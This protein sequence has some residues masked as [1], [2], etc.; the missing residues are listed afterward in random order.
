LYKLL[1]RYSKLTEEEA[2]LLFDQRKKA[3]LQSLQTSQKISPSQTQTQPIPKSTPKKQP[4]QDS[5]LKNPSQ[6]SKSPNQPRNQKTL[7]T[8]TSSK[9][10][11]DTHHKSIKNPLKNCTP[12]KSTSKST[13]PLES[14]NPTHSSLPSTTYTS[15]RSQT[16]LYHQHT[17]KKTHTSS[18]PSSSSPLT[19]LLN[20]KATTLSHKLNNKLSQNKA[21]PQQISQIQQMQNS[22][23]NLLQR[24]N[25]KLINTS[26]DG[27]K[28]IDKQNKELNNCIRKRNKSLSKGEFGKKGEIKPRSASLRESPLG[29]G[30]GKGKGRREF[31]RDRSEGSAGK[32]DEGKREARNWNKSEGSSFCAQEGE[33]EEQILKSIIALDNQIKNVKLGNKGKRKGVK[34]SEVVI[35]HFGEGGT[36]GVTVS[37]TAGSKKEPF[38]G[39]STISS[40]GPENKMNASASKKKNPARLEKKTL[41]KEESK[42]S[43]KPVMSSRTDFSLNSFRNEGYSIYNRMSIDNIKNLSACKSEITASEPKFNNSYCNQIDFTNN[44]TQAQVRCFNYSELQKLKVFPIYSNFCLGK[45]FRKEKYEL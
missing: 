31:K 32:D 20:T 43:K 27:I 38:A 34:D 44:S 30:K 1:L 28:Q 3:V 35:G 17:P 12:S 6:A 15:T 41:G 24:A 10:P 45:N 37:E 4:E 26:K 39:I 8:T 9:H 23:T 13:K 19:K 42:E 2:E 36:F 29:R 7:K 16:Q 33:T 11:K 18:Q 40:A 25:D 22:L 5:P 21:P 14:P